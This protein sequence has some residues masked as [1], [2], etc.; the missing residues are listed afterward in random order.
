MKLKSSRNCSVLWPD[1]VAFRFL[2]YFWGVGDTCFNEINFFPLEESVEG[3]AVEV[4]RGFWGLRV[5]GSGGTPPAFTAQGSPGPGL[6]YCHRR[7]WGTR[8]VELVRAW[9]P[10]WSDSLGESCDA[11][12][13]SPA[14][15]RVP[16]DPL[17]HTFLSVR[18][19]CWSRASVWTR[20]LVHR[21]T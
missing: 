9:F 12:V 18:R 10:G 4:P 19:T 11:R 21:L 3:E 15:G 17:L 5:V 20:E 8:L 2:L 7:A 1:D 16:Q 6:G 13:S 14:G